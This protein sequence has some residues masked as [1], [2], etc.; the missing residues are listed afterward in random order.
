MGESARILRGRPTVMSA[1]VPPAPVTPPLAAG[2]PA[3][4]SRHELVQ[5]K[6]RI[7]LVKM[8]FAELTSATLASGGALI[9]FGVVVALEVPTP[10]LWA[11]LGVMGA[12][13]V[14][15]L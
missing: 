5:A 8:A 15:R 6:A 12:I 11:W 13:L 1:N 2:Q 14:Y 9:A 3:P 4:A 7:E 10:T